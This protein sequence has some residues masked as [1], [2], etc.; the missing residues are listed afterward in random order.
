MRKRLYR[1]VVKR[2]CDDPG[3][4]RE[5]P[6]ERHGQAPTLQQR[7]DVALS[8]TEPSLRAYVTGEG[9]DASCRLCGYVVCVCK[10]EGDPLLYRR[11]Y[12]GEWYTPTEEEPKPD[13]WK[14]VRYT[15]EEIARIGREGIARRSKWFEEHTYKPEKRG[16]T[17]DGVARAF[18]DALDADPAYNDL[19][20]RGL[21]TRIK[22]QP[23][24]VD[25][26]TD[27]MT[28]NAMG[29]MLREREQKPILMTLRSVDDIDDVADAARHAREYRTDWVQVKP[30]EPTLLER[31]RA[32][33]LD[34]AVVVRDV[35]RRGSVIAAWATS[36]TL[37][38]FLVTDGELADFERSQKKP[39]PSLLERVQAFTDSKV[40]GARITKIVNEHDD[41]GTVRFEYEC[42]GKIEPGWAHW[43][44]LRAFEATQKKPERELTQWDASGYCQNVLYKSEAYQAWKAGKA[45]AQPEPVVTSC[46]VCGKDYRMCGHDEMHV[47][48]KKLLD[49][50]CADGSTYLP[51]GVYYA[52]TVYS[53]RQSDSFAGFHVVLEEASGG[54]SGKIGYAA[55][56][57]R[58]FDALA[59]VLRA[60][61]SGLNP[62]LAPHS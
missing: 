59:S 33:G 13:Q 58:D 56:A 32:Y 25:S 50:A 30:A 23:S 54:C 28:A 34:R 22:Y 24:A 15:P 42:Q 61:R 31:V 40:K 35:E 38:A 46:E 51:M 19:L 8:I 52:G 62:E 16:I 48:A 21:I 12:M 2:A 7:F 41:G 10:R 45:A 27:A 57:Y 26:K 44:A 36:P 4:D 6:C 39:E 60:L 17:S 18:M 20:K 53:V 5:W 37:P 29:A 55:V 14:G 3:C 11:Q 9:V 1:G 43:G 49:K 47:V